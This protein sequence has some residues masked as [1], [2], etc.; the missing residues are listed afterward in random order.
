[1]T[2][3]AGVRTIE[4][5]AHCFAKRCT[6]S[7]RHEHCCPRDGLERNPMQTDCATKRDDRSNAAKAANH[8][9]RLVSGSTKVNRLRDESRNDDYH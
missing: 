2:K 8:A 9:A 1:M 6:S 7:V 3:H 5:L 4:R